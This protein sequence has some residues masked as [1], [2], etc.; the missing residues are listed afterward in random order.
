MPNLQLK[1]PISKEKGPVRYQSMFLRSEGREATG[2]LVT[3]DLGNKL[4]HCVNELDQ[5]TQTDTQKIPQGPSTIPPNE[6]GR[7]HNVSSEN[8]ACLSPTKS[9]TTTTNASLTE[10]SVATQ[11]TEKDSDLDSDLEIIEVRSVSAPNNGTSVWGNL[12]SASLDNSSDD[13]SDEE[14]SELSTLD[15]EINH[16]LSSSNTLPFQREYY[17]QQRYGNLGSANT[18]TPP[19]HKLLPEF[20]KPHKTNTSPP[21]P[22]YRNIPPNLVYAIHRELNIWMDSAA[23][24]DLEVMEKL[25]FSLQDPIVKTKIRLPIKATTCRHFECFDFQTFCE[26]YELKPGAKQF[27]KSTLLQ[28]SRAAREAENLFL[29][30]QQRIAAGTLRPNDPAIIYPYF[31]EHGQM[32]FT[33]LYSR[34]AP[35]YKCPLC[36]EKFGLKQLYISDIFNFFVKT[37]PLHVNKVQ[38]EG[39]RFKIV[40]EDKNEE[41]QKETEVVDLSDEE[42]EP[43]NGDGNIKGENPVPESKNDEAGDEAS[44]QANQSMATDDFNDG[45]DEVLMSMSKEDGSWSHPVTLD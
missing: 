21:P 19:I 41:I 4:R 42:D 28:Q 24:D 27:L 15:T 37:T 38:L 17:T 40:E 22:G 5:N 39:A 36:D 29:K 11:N 20:F 16:A 8:G 45:L 1:G 33:E 43:V 3:I 32:F 13:G 23:D 2:L 7:G 44:D 31:S 25:V 30:Q 18:N 34:T 12:E 35:L 10:S 9:T 14:S 6:S 26:F